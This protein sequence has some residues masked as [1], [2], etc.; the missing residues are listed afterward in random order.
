MDNLQNAVNRRIVNLTANGF[1]PVINTLN[2]YRVG[3]SY[4]AANILSANVI[5]QCCERLGLSYTRFGN[6]FIIN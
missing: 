3:N 4:V 6:T 1:P 2:R 5:I